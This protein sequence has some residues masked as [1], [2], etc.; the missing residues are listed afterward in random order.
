MKNWQYNSN[1]KRGDEYNLGNWRPIRL[2]WII[3]RIIFGIMSQTIW[4][5]NVDQKGQYYHYPKELVPRINGC[6]NISQLLT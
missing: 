3:Y 5:S 6:G 4:I 1:F 2:T